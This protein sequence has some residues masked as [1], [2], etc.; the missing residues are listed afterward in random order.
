MIILASTSD[1]IQVNTT[2]GADID[3]H[4]S[5]VD[6]DLT[7]SPP[8]IT[9]G[10]TNTAILTA[11]TPT[12]VA[13]PGASTT[14][15][16]VKSMM[17]H[18]KDAATSNT[19]TVQHYDGTTT[20]ILCI[21]TLLANE[22]LMYFSADGWFVMDAAG[23]IKRSAYTGQFLGTTVLTSGTSFTTTAKT[24]TI[25]VRLI[26]GGG[27]GGGATSNASNISAAGGGASGGYAEKTFTVTP[28]TAYT[29]Q[30]GAAGAG[31]I[32][33]A[34]AGNQGTNTFFVVG[35][36]NVVANGGPGGAAA[37]AAG[38]TT[39]RLGGARPSQSTSGDLN[40]SGIAGGNGFSVSVTIAWSGF[41]A[42]G[43]F[44]GGGPS[45]NTNGNGAAATNFGAGGAGALTVGAANATGGAGSQGVIVVEEF[46]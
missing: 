5:W 45:V 12:V 9:P 25:K 28:N 33:G 41:G 44:G 24:N 38:A 6:A 29:Y 36:T 35:A 20:V 2:T 21:Y 22:T 13:A 30:I 3:V 18:N 31:G 42:D 27:A 26:G 46:T 23:G 7:T 14:R 39:T 8:G 32:N 17:I 43:P 10:R 19:V 4:A 15:R 37:P 11:T 34:N 16:N 1:I 40:G